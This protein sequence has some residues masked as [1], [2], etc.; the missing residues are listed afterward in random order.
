MQSPSPA[1]RLRTLPDP[2]DKAYASREVALSRCI[3]PAGATR[4][5]LLSFNS[6]KVSRSHTSGLTAAK[7]QIRP[8]RPGC[9]RPGAKVLRV[10][11]PAA[12]TLRTFSRAAPPKKKKKGFYNTCAQLS[13]HHLAEATSLSPNCSTFRMPSPSS[14]RP[15]QPS[16]DSLRRGRGCV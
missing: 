10:A 7:H 14:G 11:P 16:V 3:S 9:P 15:T 12:C 4:L 13:T 8:S 5:S 6:E 2:K 1:P